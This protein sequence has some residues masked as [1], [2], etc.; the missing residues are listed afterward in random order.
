MIMQIV[1]DHWEN[2]IA[3]KL[4]DGLLSLHTASTPGHI[5]EFGTMSGKTS[6]V[7]ALAIAYAEQKFIGH[8]LMSKLGPRELHLFDSFEGLPE[9][10]EKADSNSPHVQDGVWRPGA[11]KGIGPDELRSLAERH[12][13]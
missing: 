10:T 8:N 5:A 3:Q 11:C 4:F 9:I 13:K 12:L 7:L 1:F 6:E 2:E